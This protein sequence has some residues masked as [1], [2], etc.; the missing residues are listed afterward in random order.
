MEV[1]SPL[2]GSRRKEKCRKRLMSLEEE[3]KDGKID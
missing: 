1:G 2:I 3:L